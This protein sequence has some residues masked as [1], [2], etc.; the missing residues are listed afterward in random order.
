MKSP[1]P[2]I[3]ASQSPRPKIDDVAARAGVSIKTVSR[4]LNDEPNVRAETRARVK[5]AVAALNYQPDFSARSLAGRR[6]YMLGL[7]YDTVSEGYL[8]K[9]QRGILET[10]GELGYHLLVE[11]CDNEDVDA[12]R[13]VSGIAARTRVDGFIVTPPLSDNADILAALDAART[14]YVLVEP[15]YTSDATPW[16]DID[17]VAAADMLTTRL[18]DLGHRRIAFIK[19]L[20]SHGAALLRFDGFNAALSRAGVEVDPALVKQGDFTFATGLTI[21][22]GLLALTERPTAVFAAN[23]DM[24]AGVIAAASEVGLQVPTDL[25]VVGFD[26]SLAAE[27]VTPQLTTVRQPIEEMGR[28]AVA[29]LV[30]ASRGRLEEGDGAGRHAFEIVVRK[31]DGPPP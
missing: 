17:G 27:I 18:I 31:S 15:A 2:R 12:G 23:D 9:L 19:G 5:E 20:E 30:A 26:D 10:C 16:V 7:L 4:V 8:N 24:A 14:P 21:G 29:F 11:R 3:V 6:S 28:A 25:S 22:R 13:R 1:P